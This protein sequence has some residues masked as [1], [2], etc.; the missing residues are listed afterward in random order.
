MADPLVTFLRHD[1]FTLEPERIGPCDWLLCDVACYPERLYDWICR[2]L[3]SGFCGNM[4]C[5]VKIQG[6]INWQLIDRFAAL[7]DSRIVHL[8]YNKHE[9][10]W[11]KIPQPQTP[12]LF[13]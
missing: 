10:T 12:Q 4:I 5:T 9:L 6:A 1:A 2:Q 7:P 13:S 11:I 3:A 8:N